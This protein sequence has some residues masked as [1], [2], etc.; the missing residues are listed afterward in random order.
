MIIKEL[1]A[2]TRVLETNL[3]PELNITGVAY[4]S[5]KVQPGDLF[6]AITGF[7]TDGNRYIPMALE[8]GAL[9][10]VTAASRRVLRNRMAESS[11]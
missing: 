6:V 4:D 11:S 2:G 10:V 1:L 5:R 3:D 8:K 9:A 7:A